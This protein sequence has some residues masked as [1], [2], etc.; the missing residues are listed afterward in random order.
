MNQ[1]VNNVVTI[2]MLRG[3]AE[4]AAILKNVATE[5]TDVQEAFAL[6]LALSSL[7]ER[8]CET[9]ATGVSEK[10]IKETI[11]F[12]KENLQQAKY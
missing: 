12:V 9:S 5:L 11:D 10:E 8:E 2:L 1:S 3:E 6:G 7:L 4:E